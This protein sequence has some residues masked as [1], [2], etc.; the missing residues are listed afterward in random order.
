[1]SEHD[2]SKQPD[3]GGEGAAAAALTVASVATAAFPPLGLIAFPLAIGGIVAARLSEKR[4]ARK[5]REKADQA[6]AAAKAEAQA[7]EDR[8]RRHEIAVAEASR[9]VPEPKPDRLALMA[10]AKAMRDRLLDELERSGLT[11]IAYDSARR[12]IEQIYV[13]ELGKGALK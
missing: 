8:K 5:E 6:A 12:R 11:G 7:E 3:G 1:M 9:P 4:R 2:E 10:A 13:N